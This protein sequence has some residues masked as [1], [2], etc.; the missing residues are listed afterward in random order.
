M[1]TVT[2]AN[3]AARI[4]V[5]EDDTQLVDVLVGHLGRADYVVGLAADGRAVLGAIAAF[6]PDLVLLDRRLPTP[7]GLELCRDLR[8]RSGIPVIM[9]TGP[10]DE[11]QRIAGLEAGAD[12]CLVTPFS[13]RELL[14]RVRSVLRRTMSPV[15]AQR[16]S[17][18]LTVDDLMLDTATGRVF[19]GGRP[20]ALTGREFD[21]LR[22]FF[23]HRGQ[24]HSRD[25][26]LR[27]VWKWSF[28]DSATV[29]VY[30]RRLRE[31]IEDDPGRPRLLVTEWGA[32]YRFGP[33][34]TARG[35]VTVN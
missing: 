12:D 21:L 16:S 25:D 17:T 7:G 10:G 5:A 18:E 4:L 3:E 29:T 13:P 24:V 26:L 31:K 8:R 6:Q 27:E 20:V 30:V 28:G 19:K 1:T 9:L 33:P 34:M 35:I 2:R 14:L 23:T 15:P 32:G 22:F 11:N